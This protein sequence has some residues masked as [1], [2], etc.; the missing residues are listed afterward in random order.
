MQKMA[1]TILILLFLCTTAH[2]AVDFS[3]A[4][5]NAYLDSGS[6][7]FTP[8]GTTLN[9]NASDGNAS[10]AWGSYSA[11]FDGSLGGTATLN[12]SSMSGNGQLGMRKYI[13]RNTS[14]NRIL[15]EIYINNW[16]GRK[17]LRYRIRERSDDYSIDNKL[18]VGYFGDNGSDTWSLGENLTMGF[19]YK[20]SVL[21]F[22]CSKFPGQLSQVY[23]PQIAA[24]EESD[25]QIYA[26]T[27]N[28]GN[29][30]GTVSDLNIDT[31]FMNFFIC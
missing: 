6:V 16:D 5:W 24:T 8:S 12:I 18:A 29:M 30:I 9:I 25:L 28:N 13:A 2:A 27:E 21:Y 26:Y 7:T 15:V 31:S 17:T 22:Y 4:E 10:E 1:M 14:G 23:L 11:Y 19:W 20:N 3:G